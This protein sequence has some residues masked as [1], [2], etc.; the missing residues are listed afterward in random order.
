M[1]PMER[2]LGLEEED[3]FADQR[4]VSYT[5]SASMAQ[6][7]CTRPHTSQAL[8]TN[9]AHQTIDPIGVLLRLADNDR[10]ALLQDL[11]YRDKRLER[12]DL[13]GKDRLATDP[14]TV[15]AFRFAPTVRENTHT[16]MPAQ[17]AAEDLWSHV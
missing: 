9:T 3:I 4:T 14:D 8:T 15:S 6:P 5:P 13:I 12:L 11:V 2:Q 16:F 1:I 7:S 17:K 10:M